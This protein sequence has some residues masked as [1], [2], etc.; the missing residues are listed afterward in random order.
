MKV[1]P[2][3]A[4]F[5]NI[6]SEWIIDLNT[7]CKAIKRLENNIGENL[8]GFEYGNVFWDTTSKNRSRKEIIHKLDFIKIK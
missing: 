8:D 4:P 7:T 3:L 5:N 2:D 6:N 1:D